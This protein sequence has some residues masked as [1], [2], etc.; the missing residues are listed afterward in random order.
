MDGRLQDFRGDFA[1]AVSIWIVTGEGRR[2]QAWREYNKRNIVGQF[3]KEVFNMIEVNL[4]WSRLSIYVVGLLIVAYSTAHHG[5]FDM[6]RKMSISAFMK[7]TIALIFIALV[8]YAM[9]FL[10]VNIPKYGGI[11]IFIQYIIE[12]GYITFLM[13]LWLRC[14]YSYFESFKKPAAV[15]CLWIVNQFLGFVPSMFTFIIFSAAAFL[16]LKKSGKES[17]PLQN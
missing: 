8:Q 15:I 9:M 4:F 12:T 6:T 11:C 1:G 13:T 14:Y 7:W 17:A 5:Y 10:D 16:F 2:Y 3:I